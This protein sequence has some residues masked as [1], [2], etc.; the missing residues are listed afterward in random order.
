MGEQK[1]QDNGENRV[2]IK[3]R[4]KKNQGAA[5]LEGIQENQSML[6]LFVVI[7]AALAVILISIM[8]LDIAAIPVCAIVLLEAGIAACLHDVPIW[9][10]ALVVIAQVIVGVLSGMLVFMLLCAVIYVAAI[11]SFR[12]IRD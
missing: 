1:N 3:E 2:S 12:F 5:F 6:I 4:R 10:H 7:V 9:L 8:A 11:F